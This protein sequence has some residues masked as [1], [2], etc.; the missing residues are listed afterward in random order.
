LC[1]LRYNF[2]KIAQYKQL[3]LEEAEEKMNR[4]RNSAS[5]YE[6][7]MMKAGANGAA[8]FSSDVKKLDNV[9]AGTTGRVQPKKGDRNEDG[10]QSDIG[11][12]DGEGET[13]R[14]NR[15]GPTTKG[16]EE[17]D[18]EGR[19]DRDFDMDD[20]IEKGIMFFVKPRFLRFYIVHTAKIERIV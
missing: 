19:K 7:W 4:R 16:M 17:D 2:S 5:G 14:K 6:R 3:T 8:A 10:D 18:E 12:E 20:E 9:N 13:A 1:G 11:E 15:H